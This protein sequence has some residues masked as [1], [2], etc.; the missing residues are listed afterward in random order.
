MTNRSATPAEQIA[1]L[2]RELHGEVTT[3]EPIYRPRR[4]RRSATRTAT[5]T[6]K[7]TY[8]TR[9]P[10]LLDQLAITSQHHTQATIHLR[11]WIPDTPHPD[12]PSRC[13]RPTGRLDANGNQILGCEGDCWHGR[14]TA[15]GT[16]QRPVTTSVPGAALPQGSPGWDPDGAASPITSGGGFESS[17]PI[18]DAWHVREAVLAG[19]D[20]IGHDL[21]ARGWRPP[22]TMVDIAL[23]DEA[24]G[25]WIADRLSHYVRQARTALTYDVPSVPLREVYCPDCRGEMR[26]RRDGDSDVWCAGLIHGPQPAGEQWPPARGC[27]ARWPR[28]DLVNL[29]AAQEGA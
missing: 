21:H 6:E 28:Y 29:L 17:E 10:G 24:E 13:G 12:N 19:L 27:G 11:R 2:L 1:A 5:I 14:W 4:V 15:A 3:S 18:S 22:L 23:K 20:Q 26:F 25:Q 7:T 8:V 16:E 9:Q